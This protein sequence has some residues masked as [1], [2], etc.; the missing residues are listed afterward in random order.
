VIIVICT[1]IQSFHLIITVPL[2]VTIIIGTLGKIADEPADCVTIHIGKQRGQEAPA[3]DHFIEYLYCG[4]AAI[5]D[6]DFIVLQF[7][8]CAGPSGERYIVINYQNFVLFYYR[9]PL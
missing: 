7:Q 2:A 8:K 6:T 5:G 4:L 9:S 3:M 1:D